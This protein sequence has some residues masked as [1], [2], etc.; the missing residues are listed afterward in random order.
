MRI[1]KNPKEI[2]YCV[3]CGNPSTLKYPYRFTQPKEK[4]R[5]SKCATNYTKRDPKKYQEWRKRTKN[6]ITEKYK[7]PV[8]K[9]NQKNGIINKYKDP[10]F[11]ENIKNGAKKRNED[12][13]YRKK[14]KNAAQKRSKDPIWRAKQRITAQAKE[15]RIKISATSL[16]IKVE[17]WNGFAY[18]HDYCEK[19]S[20]PKLKIRKRVRARYNDMCVL[21][22]KTYKQNNNRHMHVHH[23][24][25]NKNA[26]CKGEKNDW[27]FATLCD[28]CHGKYGKS[29]Y[30]KY[31]LMEIISIEYGNKCM[32][33]LEEYNKLY[34]DGSESDRKWGISNGS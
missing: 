34:P 9:E 15:R 16:G 26:C 17:E 5:C 27:L 13:L 33:S 29:T 28:K 3:D 7:D 8:Y 32:L 20:D 11:Y 2:R 10:K 4:Y 12:P 30:Y 19:W 31:N 25:R 24:N 14:I 22:H 1:A 18:A 21:C 6:T 23:I